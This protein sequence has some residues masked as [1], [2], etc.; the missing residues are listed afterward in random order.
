VNSH[1]GLVYGYLCLKLG[2]TPD[3]MKEFREKNYRGFL[4]LMGIASRI[5]SETYGG[6]EF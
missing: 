2:K 5:I 4:F 1:E 6:C 3:E